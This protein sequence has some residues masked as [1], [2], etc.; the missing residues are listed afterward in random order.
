MEEKHLEVNIRS[1]IKVFILVE[2]TQSLLWPDIG[3][4][5]K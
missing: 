5:F 3:P 2:G 4:R 1:A